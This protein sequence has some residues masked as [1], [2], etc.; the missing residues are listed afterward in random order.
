M[1]TRGQSRAD[2]PTGGHTTVGGGVTRGS[3]TTA[4]P[5]TAGDSL[6]HPF[7]IGSDATDVD[8]DVDVPRHDNSKHEHQRNDQ[9]VNSQQS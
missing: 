4:G 2:K 6:E 5:T 7:I 1:T 9:S 3:T 8:V